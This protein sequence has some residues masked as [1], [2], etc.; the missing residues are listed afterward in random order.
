[1]SMLAAAFLL[2]AT[3]T[4]V[5]GWYDNLTNDIVT[6]TTHV[7]ESRG[8]KAFI[9]VCL[10]VCL[11]GG[12]AQWY[13]RTLASDRRTFLPVLRLTASRTDDH[14]VGQTSAVGQP[15]RPTHPFILTGSISE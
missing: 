8:S 3:A 5:T 1:M 4:V 14:F 10:S 15:T 12:V 9:H 11:F 2:T 7:D 13:Y 6:V